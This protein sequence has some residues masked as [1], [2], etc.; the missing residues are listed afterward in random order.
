M[1]SSNSNCILFN[2]SHIINYF[3]PIHNYCL[4]YSPIKNIKLS[5]DKTIINHFIYLL[6]TVINY[7]MHIHLHPAC[8]IYKNDQEINLSFLSRYALNQKFLH[9]EIH[10][11]K[12]INLYGQ[13]IS[14]TYFAILIQDSKSLI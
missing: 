13:S 7:N 14:P 6:L 4:K 12:N 9:K 2:F 1:A 10:L 3:L 8:L 5:A 11:A